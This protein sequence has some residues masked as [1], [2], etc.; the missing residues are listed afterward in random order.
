MLSVEAIK[1]I[2]GISENVDLEISDMIK[3]INITFY[4]NNGNVSE[5]TKI[6]V[7]DFLSSLKKLNINI[8]SFEDVWQ[9]IPLQKRVKRF[10]KYL[11]NNIIWLLRYFFRKPQTSFFLSFKTICKLCS[12]WKI[13]HGIS[14]ICV[15]EQNEKDL[16]MQHISNFKTNSVITIVDLPPHIN[17]KSD[18]LAHFDTSMSM[19]AYHMTNIIIAVGQSIW[20]TYNFNASHPTFN[21]PDNNLTEHIY[22]SII[23]KIAAPIS[24]HKLEEFI[25]LDRNFDPDDHDNRN[26]INIMFDGAQLF[27]LTNLFPKGKSIDELPFRNNFHKLI[28][29]LHLDSRSGM[30]FG[31]IAHQLP[32][33]IHEVQSLK[34]FILLYPGAFVDKDYF[35]NEHGDIYIY[36]ESNKSKIVLKIPDVWVMTL[37]SGANKTKFN[38][39]L[40]LIKIGLIN[41]KMYMQLPIGLNQDNTYKPSFDTKVILAHAVCNALIA[42]LFKFYKINDDFVQMIKNDGI[43]ISHWHGYFND[44]KIP[45]KMI[46]HGKNNPHVSCS[47]PQ[48]AI[49][50]FQGKFSNIFDILENILEYKGDIHVEPHHG[51][52]VSYSTLSDL[53]KFII[54]NKDCTELGNKYL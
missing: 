42:S 2:L 54:N 35:I 20:I 7:D 34:D 18:F 19:F 47:S 31:F 12:K 40:D 6:F 46:V 4:P 52:N 49:Y 13:R 48:S 27:A 16:V 43:S 26:S 5:K 44:E 41:G 29:K 11:L 21:F 10:I 23:P 9:K 25:I 53:A 15:G 3:K 28:G 39:N 33:M 30:S 36:I 37:R 50:A 1:T 45:D 22:N 51:I 24:P 8:L 17:K 14:I 38:K 32:T